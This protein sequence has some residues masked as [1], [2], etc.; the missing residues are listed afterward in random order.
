MNNMI[1]S[2]SLYTSTS[3]NE[4]LH[5]PISIANGVFESNSFDGFR[6]LKENES[7]TQSA[8]VSRL[9]EVIRG[10]GILAKI[11]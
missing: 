3:I 4:A 11:R 1:A 8:I 2:I 10:I 9:N 6:K 7:K 5:L